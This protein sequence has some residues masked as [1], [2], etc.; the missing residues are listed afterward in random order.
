MQADIYKLCL[1]TL[2]DFRCYRPA[3]SGDAAL[4]ANFPIATCT[5]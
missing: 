1:A 3:S 4:P 5:A 2:A